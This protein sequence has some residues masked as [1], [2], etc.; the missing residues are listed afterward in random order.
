MSLS[1]EQRLFAL[2][3]RNRIEDERDAAYGRAMEERRLRYEVLLKENPQL[4]V[5]S[6]PFLLTDSCCAVGTI[7]PPTCEVHSALCG[8]DQ[9]IPV[10]ICGCRPASGSPLSVSANPDLEEKALSET[11]SP[12]CMKSNCKRR[13]SRSSLLEFFR[14]VVECSRVESNSRNKGK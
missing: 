6:L 8:G 2:E 4:N 9:S 13:I 11:K 12:F 14:R 3:E 1:I 5:W 7:L 10:D